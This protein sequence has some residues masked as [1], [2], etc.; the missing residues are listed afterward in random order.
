MR[1][2]TTKQAKIVRYVEA[3]GRPVGMA[4]LHRYLYPKKVRAGSVPWNVECVVKKGALVF[5]SGGG[6][7]RGMAV[8]IPERAAEYLGDEW[9]RFP[10][11]GRRGDDE[12][13]IYYWRGY[14]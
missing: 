13:D 5:V 14:R 1:K 11:R 3:A 10:Y 6:P 8:D 9:S 12:G 7:Q 2:L 4:E